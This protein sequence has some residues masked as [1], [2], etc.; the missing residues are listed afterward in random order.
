MSAGFRRISVSLPEGDLEALRKIAGIR[1]RP[2]AWLAREA[3]AAWLDSES[4]RLKDD[5]AAERGTP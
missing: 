5:Y 4:E 2:V 3:I 1:Q